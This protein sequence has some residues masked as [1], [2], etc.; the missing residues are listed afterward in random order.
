MLR[1]DYSEKSDINILYER[2]GAFHNGVLKAL[3]PKQSFPAPKVA[4]LSLTEFDSTTLSLDPATKPSRW[5]FDRE[6]VMAL[7]NSR[8]RPKVA[9]LNNIAELTRFRIQCDLKKTR[10][11][12]A[13]TGALD[14]FLKEES[15]QGK[16][17]AEKSKRAEGAVQAQDGEERKESK[18][19][20]D[21]KVSEKKDCETTQP[22]NQDYATS[23]IVIKKKEIDLTTSLIQDGVNVDSLSA[24]A[25][26][27]LV[28]F[29]RTFSQSEDEGENDEDERDD[30][31]SW[32]HSAY[33]GGSYD[34][35][36]GSE[37]HPDAWKNCDR[38]FYGIRP[39]C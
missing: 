22:P 17:A 10:E 13:V 34:F 11:L 18:K 32:E 3:T 37:W 14:S 1:L 24:T 29:S 26:F 15:K 2:G 38:S 20:E 23:A 28:S 6:T 27:Q 7:V 8:R 35:S 5:M 9:E 21:E 16:E 4:L 31:E 33:L 25:T 36:S 39:L 12:V 19:Q 30:P